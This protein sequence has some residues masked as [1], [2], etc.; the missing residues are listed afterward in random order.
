MIDFSREDDTRAAFSHL[1]DSLAPVIVHD[2]PSRKKD[3]CRYFN[4]EGSD[5]VMNDIAA[6][7]QERW[8]RGTVRIFSDMQAEQLVRINGPDL[9]SSIEVKVK[10]FQCDRVVNDAALLLAPND[11]S[12]DAA[13]CRLQAMLAD[14]EEDMIVSKEEFKGLYPDTQLVLETYELDFSTKIKATTTEMA[15]WYHSQKYL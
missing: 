10:T 1:T 3:I 11:I 12:P 6:D 8:I 9:A 2:F 5:W 7:E 13:A 14:V 15:R 4:W